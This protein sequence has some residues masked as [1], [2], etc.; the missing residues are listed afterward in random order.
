ML[1]LLTVDYIPDCITGDVGD[2]PEGS[3]ARR[4]C[5]AAEETVFSFV[6]RFEGFDFENF[7]N[8]L[9]SF[10]ISLRLSFEIIPANYIKGILIYFNVNLIRM[11]IPIKGKSKPLE[12]STGEWSLKSPS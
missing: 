8:T 2:I 5:A 7:Q 3:S 10:V 12:S 9:S 11:Y 4:N 6:M 1:T